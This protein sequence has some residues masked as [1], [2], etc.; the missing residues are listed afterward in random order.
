M[1]TEVVVSHVL[2]AFSLPLR[3]QLS[4]S[5]GLTKCRTGP[6]LGQAETGRISI[7]LTSNLL[8]MFNQCYMLFNFFQIFLIFLRL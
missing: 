5:H 8:E 4:L 3:V 2:S 1:G 6:A 7:I